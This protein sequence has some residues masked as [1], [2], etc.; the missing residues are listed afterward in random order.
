[1]GTLPLPAHD[2]ANPSNNMSLASLPVCPFGRPT[3]CDNEGECGGLCLMEVPPVDCLEF[4]IELPD[5]TQEVVSGLKVGGFC[6]SNCRD[7]ECE[8]TDPAF[9]GTYD[10]NNCGL[11]D[12]FVKIDCNLPPASPPLPPMA[13]PHAP[14]Q[15]HAVQS[16]EPAIV[17]A[18]VAVIAIV[19]VLLAIMWTFGRETKA[20]AFLQSRRRIRTSTM[21]TPLAA[22]DSA[23]QPHGG[24]SG[25]APVVS[26][27]AVEL[28]LNGTGSGEADSS[29]AEVQYSMT[30]AIVH[31]LPGHGRLGFVLVDDEVT[32][33]AGHPLSFPQVVEISPDGAAAASQAMRLGDRIVSVNAEPV[34]CCDLSV[35]LMLLKKAKGPSL[36]LG[37][38]RPRDLE[39]ALAVSLEEH[40]RQGHAQDTELSLAIS[41]SAAEQEANGGESA[42]SLSEAKPPPDEAA[43]PPY[44]GKGK[45]KALA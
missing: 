1:M 7:L 39:E 14:A 11:I 3:R 12:V 36:T 43:S 40:E 35:A 26:P 10:A 38:L 25:V 8:G 34:G 19:A 28:R 16:D 45:G 30:E 17:V 18:I 23:E 21:T 2:E 22:A 6:A 32:H 24:P 13:P 15:L 44:V 9:C 5:C 42:S 41:L 31:R 27:L 4:G 37:L 29:P 33:E 20:L